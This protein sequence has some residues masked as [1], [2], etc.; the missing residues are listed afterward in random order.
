MIFMK[1]P[2]SLHKIS[3]IIMLNRRI[4]RIKAFKTIYS[5]AV[6][7]DMDQAKASQMLDASC[8]A[9]RDLYLFMLSVVSPLTAESRS[10]IE[11]AKGKINPT[12]EDLSANEKFADNA[13][14]TYLENDPDF[15]R[16]LG[17][18]AFSWQPYDIVIRDIFDSVQTKEWYSEYMASANTSLKEDC[19]L[20]CHIFEEEF[21]DNK[22][23][24]PIL[25]D[26]SIYWN[27]DLCYALSW[28]LRSL[29][30]IAAGRG[31]RLP[32]LY[33][34]DVV[35]A[36]NK[37]ADVD[38][39]SDFVHKLVRCALSGYEGYFQK[40]TSLVPGWE[41]DR[42]FSSDMAIIACALAEIENFP[43]IPSRVSINEYVDISKFYCSPKSRSFINGV[44]D[45]I[46]KENNLI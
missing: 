11:A 40:V 1:M 20:F 4:L 34:S 15:T 30:D 2:L 41:S 33:M 42:L 3:M 9:V 31:W 45:R 17:K 38:S 12:A 26:L 16:I 14:A 23:L 19:A 44:L 18:K 46:V 32:E 29:D 7:G 22:A 25:E 24:E 43:D 36:R 6:T 35:K 39:D 13:L 28:C 10:R 5:Y 37:D 8:Q 21:A 27:D